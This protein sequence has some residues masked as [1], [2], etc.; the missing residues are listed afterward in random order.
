[1]M[2]K[3]AIE[4]VPKI[5]GYKLARDGLCKPPLPALFNFSVTNRCQS[6]C[7]TCSIWKLYIE[8]PELEEGELKL[9]EI[10]KT[11]QSMGH[12][13]LLN[14]CGGEPFLREDLPEICGLACEYLTPRVIHSPTNCLA[15][16]QIEERVIGILERIKGTSLTIKVSVDGVGEKHDYIRGV[17]GNFNKFVDTY[18][19]LREVRKGYPNF[20]LDAG[21]TVSN[22]NI[23]DI[24][25]LDEYVSENMDFDNFL[26]EIADLRGELFNLD[27]GIRPTGEDYTKVINYLME[28][29][30]E[31]MRNSRKLSKMT[32][33]LRL[34]YY[35]RAARVL[36][37][38]ARAT[39]CYA[40]ISNAHLN[41]W[42]G[43]WPCNV[44]AFE[45]EMGN[46]RDFDYD[47]KK[48]WHSK[49]ANE[50]RKWIKSNHCSCPL[51][52]QAF[53]DTVMNPRE[54]LKV[55]RYYVGGGRT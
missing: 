27:L 55:V 36:R 20:Y 12:L 13:F 29:V 43:V 24:E 41:P 54:L 52:G 16:K 32:Q 38:N 44:L 47:F 21:V 22:Y 53:L 49:Q 3:Y 2:M 26:H 17:K 45:K 46:V 6:Q 48:L 4:L 19:R 18:K 42:G 33:A 39:P 23:R 5:I 40:A 7:K 1:M 11:F 37:E 15:P 14:I 50:V 25:E 28:Q 35:D 8:K 34:V 30:K 10:E 51:V 31:D 9:W